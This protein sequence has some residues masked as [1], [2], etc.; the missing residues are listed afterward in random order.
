MGIFVRQVNHNSTAAGLMMKYLSSVV[1]TLDFQFL[2]DY[3]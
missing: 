2:S 1:I 3:S